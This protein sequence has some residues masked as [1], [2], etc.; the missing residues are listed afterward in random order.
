ML[1]LL[2]LS[3]HGEDSSQSSLAPVQG[4][5]HGRQ[6]SMNF[7]NISPSRGLQFFTNCSSTVSFHRVQPFKNRLL[8][9]GFPMGT[10]V[11]PENLLQRGLLSLRGHRSC[12]K[13]APVSAHQRLIASSNYIHLVHCGVL[14]RIHCGYLVNHCLHE[15]QRDNL[16]CHCLLHRLQGNFCS[17]A[18]SKSSSSFFNDL[19]VCRAACL[20]YSFFLSCSC[21]GLF[22]PF[23]NV[24]S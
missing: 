1:S 8:Q 2:L 13:P 5:S 16:L 15:L 10:E 22:L 3:P 21:T 7:S 4:P 12:Q 11:F 17:G 20:T 24:F 6:L 23:L 19:G 18:W 9:H 14:P